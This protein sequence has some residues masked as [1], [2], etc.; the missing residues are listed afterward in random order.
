M[1]KIKTKALLS[2]AIFCSIL[3]SAA[4]AQT[5]PVKGHVA[6]EK[7]QA[8]GGV[9]VVLTGTDKGTVTNSK[10]DFTLNANADATLTISLI[11]Y[12]PVTVSAQPSLSISLKRGENTLTDVVVIGYGSVR[13]QA[14]TGSVATV[15]QKD[16]QKGVITTP[17]QLIAGKIAGV[18]ITSNGGSPGAGSVIRIRQGAS[19]TA[20]N[21]PL[22]VIDGLPL[23]GNNIYGASNPL[24]LINPND[25]ETFTV[26]K[27]A[28]ATAIYGNRASNGVILITTKKGSGKTPK[29]SFSTQLSV[30]TIAKKMDVQSADEFRRFVDSTGG[31]TYD[32][33]HTFKS[34]L[35]AANTDWQDEIFQKAVSTDNN[36]SVSGSAKNVPYRVSLGY[37][38]QN[39]ILKTDNLERFSGAISLSP[40]FF[41]NHLK[42]QINV[43]GTVSNARFANGAAISSAVYFDPTQPVH[44]PSPYGDYFEW[45]SSGTLNKLAPRNPVALLDL[46]HNNSD[47]KRSIGNIQLDYSFHFLPELHANL[48]LGYDLAKGEGKINVPAYAAQNFLDTGLANKYSNRINNKVSEFYFSYIK[49]L[50]SIKSNINAVAGYGYYNN[51]STNDNY[52][53]FRANGDTMPGTKPLFAVDKPENTLLSFYGRLIYTYNNKYILSATMRGDASSRYSKDTRW[54]YFPSVAL[55]W[56]LKN[57]GFL[58]HAN[59]L[60]LLN[61]RLSY[62]KTGNQDGVNNYPYQAVYSLSGNGS[63]QQFGNEYYNM[64]TPAAYDADIK[65]E[66]TETYNAGIDYGFFKNR[67]TGSVDAYFKKTKDLL[68]ETNIPAGSNFSTRLLTN[69]GNVENKGV[70]FLIN[71]EVIQKKRYSWSVG[72]NAAYNE[73]EVKNLLLVPDPSYAG[74]AVNNQQ[75]NTV[76][77]QIRSFYVYK[78]EYLNGRPVEGV[79]KDLNH[80][81]IINQNDKYHFKSPF[82]KWVFGFSTQFTYDKWTISTVLRANVGNY[83][84][85]GIYVGAG[86]ANILNPLGYLSNSINDI[87]NTGFTYGQEL[88]DYYIENASFLKMDNVGL[89]YALGKIMHNKVGMQ[90]NANCQ[91]VFTVTKYKGI[92]PEIYGGMDNTIYPRPRTYTLSVNLQF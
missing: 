77:Y 47:V 45:A 44:A 6:D 2:F 36:I 13:R 41:D 83:M 34:L 92:D 81:G 3:L 66:E 82:P 85:N 12:E 25:I 23:S 39:G 28:A 4:M 70:E 87:K 69:V 1:R 27:D 71:A 90:I 5:I 46:Y 35:G 65:W 18:S 75:I 88:S 78:Q 84:Y 60:S 17:E 58:S 74:G 19:L 55:T 15:G 63:L 32:G 37:L 7:G 76:G 40:N 80:D 51:L 24:S 62:G 30:A 20:S 11:G 29:I 14:L 43:K 79:Y 54:G 61:L 38:N 16:F 57:E 72:F 56:K 68:Y 33:T 26:L 21:D 31:G 91:N 89:S 67:I 9:S 59:A 49:D 73:N 48:N 52:A 22:I 86:K 50:K 8:L 10:G 64:G 53:S 42:V